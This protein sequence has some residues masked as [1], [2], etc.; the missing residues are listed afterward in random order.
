MSDKDLKLR[1]HP[2]PLFIIIIYV[3]DVFPFFGTIS[4]SVRHMVALSF[5][6]IIIIIIAV[7]ASC[8]RLLFLFWLL[9]GG[10]YIIIIIIIMFY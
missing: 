8:Y 9:C 5:Y 2:A 6:I 1:P 4:L 3:G 7:T 10:I